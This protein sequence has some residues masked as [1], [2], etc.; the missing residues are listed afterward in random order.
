MKHAKVLLV[1]D[2]EICREVARAALEAKGFEVLALSSPFGFGAALARMRPDIVLVDAS[3]PGLQGDK[4]V[5][6]TLRNSTHRCP[7][8]FY[9]DR[10]AAELHEIVRSSGAQGFIQKSGD[11][12]RLCRSVAEY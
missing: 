7:I 9:S 6:L 2:S 10:P 5:E 3:M 12:D 1:D 11:I 8:V 4:L